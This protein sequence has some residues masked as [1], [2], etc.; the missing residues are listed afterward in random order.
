MLSLFIRYNKSKN[1]VKIFNQEKIL[2]LTKFSPIGM[3]A[4]RSTGMH[5]CL[6]RS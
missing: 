3:H 2:Y 1:F 5:F 4:Y 6:H